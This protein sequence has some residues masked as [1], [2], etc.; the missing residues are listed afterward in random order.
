MLP[1]CSRTW[2]KF[3]PM[4]INIYRRNLPH[5]RL[6]GATYFITWR[7]QR[8]Q[9][10]LRP[11]ERT[12][13]QTAILHFDGVRYDISAFVVMDD[14]I[15]VLLKPEPGWELKSITHSWK[16]F[17]ANQI[18]RKYHRKGGIWQKECFDRIIRNEKE[19]LKQ[20][21]YILGNPFVRWPELEEYSWVGIG[22]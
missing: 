11:E 3:V 18:Q 10:P 8:N 19:Y 21:N 16:S 15:H 9:P 1:F 13:V 14:H 5:W 7:L 2:Q 12:L 6:E 4:N 22:R 20:G 17:T